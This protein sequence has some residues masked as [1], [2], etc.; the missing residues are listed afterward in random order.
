MG[1][2]TFTGFNGRYFESVPKGIVC[3]EMFSTTA[4]DNAIWSKVEIMDNTISASG[5]TNQVLVSVYRDIRSGDG[6][7][8]SDLQTIIMDNEMSG[9]RSDGVQV[10]LW[11]GAYENDLSRHHQRRQQ[12]R[13]RS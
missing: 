7:R 3:S 13:S 12:R 11:D 4:S 6:N 5:A 8:T 2:P 10:T 9:A 1:M